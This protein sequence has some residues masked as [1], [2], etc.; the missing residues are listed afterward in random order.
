MASFVVF[1]TSEYLLVRLHLRDTYC[2]IHLLSESHFSS[3][4]SLK[5]WQQTKT[6]CPTYK[7]RAAVAGV[8]GGEEAVR[9]SRAVA[10]PFEQVWESLIPQ[11]IW[12]GSDFGFIWCIHPQLRLIDFEMDIAKRISLSQCRDNARG[13]LQ[14]LSQLWEILTPRW[15]AVFWTLEAELDLDNMG[16]IEGSDLPWINA[17]FTVKTRVHGHSLDTKKI[18]RY[19][20]YEKYGLKVASP[21]FMSLS[22]LSHYMYQFDIGGGGGTTFSGTLDKLAMPGVLFHHI[23]QTKDYYHDLLV[24]WMHYIPVEEGLSD[25]RAMYE[26]AVANGEQAMRIS[27]AASDFV[28]SWATP[29]VM[30]GMYNKYFIDT[31]RPVVDAYESSG[32]D[33]PKILKERKWTLIATVS[34]KDVNFKYTKEPRA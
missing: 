24:P 18:D 8:V 16:E 14:C 15:R 13:I 29:D 4:N 2:I 27:E 5:Q 12:R 31:L 9:G 7:D 11:I 20:P 6:I 34:G 33:V 25:L 17:R 1:K 26:W 10:I 23:T 22:A 3:C 32:E 21:D 28:R 30:D 19:T